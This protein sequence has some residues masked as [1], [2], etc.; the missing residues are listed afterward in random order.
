MSAAANSMISA[1]SG[2]V[3]R[4]AEG[5]ESRKESGTLESRALQRT[6]LVFG[7]IAV[8]ITAPEAVSN[9]PSSI[10]AVGSELRVGADA[11]AASGVPSG[12]RARSYPSRQCDALGCGSN[13]SKIK[14]QRMSAV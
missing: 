8:E 7:S 5:S 11:G 3:A 12:G 13:P 1:Q 4:G 9:H 10:G 2:S 6:R 14:S